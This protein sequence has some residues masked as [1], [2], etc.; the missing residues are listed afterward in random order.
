MEKKIII[1]LFMILI[2]TSISSLS[3]TLANPND[4]GEARFSINAVNIE[5]DWE[6]TFGGIASDQFPS[7]IQT[8]DS[9]FALLGLTDSYGAGGLDSWLIKTDATGFPEWNRTFG[10]PNDD[11][12]LSLIQTTDGGFALAGGTSS[13][14]TGEDG[15]FV[16]TDA[17]GQTEWN[18]TIGG[19]AGDAVGDPIQTADGGFVLGGSTESYGA[20]GL[21]FWLVKTNSTGQVQWNHTFGDPNNNEL[22]SFIQTADGGFALGGLI[23]LSN[24]PQ[25]TWLVKTDANGQAEWN[26]TFGGPGWNYLTALIQTA[27][28]G[29]VLAEQQQLFKTNMTGQVEWNSVDRPFDGSIQDAIQMT[30]GGFAICGYGGGSA[31]NVDGLLGKINANGHVEWNITFGGSANDVFNSVIELADGNFVL[32]GWTESYGAG[33]EDIWLIKTKSS[34]VTDTTTTTTGTTTTP[35]TTATTTQASP[36]WTPLLVFMSITALLIPRKRKEKY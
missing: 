7:L 35:T 31:F 11:E 21:D 10:G 5:I 3:P 12:V 13:F 36:S 9:G 18:T 33:L 8:A 6:R 29:F 28:E 17:N 24:N 25:D 15:W 16:K 26:Q 27:D 20:G 1:G 22:L 34:T 2:L 32:A 30:D 19:S 23:G 14:G 4:V